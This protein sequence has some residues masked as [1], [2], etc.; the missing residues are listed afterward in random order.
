[1]QC[2]RR[3]SRWGDAPLLDKD[4]RAKLAAITD[5]DIA[6]IFK[7]LLRYRYLPV[8]FI[9][10]LGGGSLGYLVDRLNLL[11]RRPNVFVRRPVQQRANAF[12]NRYRLIYE[13]ADK[14]LRVMEE[15]GFEFQRSRA[16]GSFAHELM[17]CEI[18]ASF[19]LG[20]RDAGV[21]FITWQ[22]I[23]KSQALPESTRQ[24]PRPF[25]IPV[26]VMIDGAPRDIHI[27]ADGHPFGVG[28]PRD[29]KTSYFF[30]PGIEADCGTEPIDASNF[31]RSSIAKKFTAYLAIREGE[32]HRSHFGFPNLFVPIITTN[33]ARLASMMKVLERMTGGQGSRIFLFRTFP[34]FASCDRS[35]T[36]SGE[37]LTGDWQRVGY[38]PFNFVTL[39]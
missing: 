32:V 8:D 11:S 19:E 29:G 33:E 1:M 27:A 12:A 22:D 38:P 35:P 13:L 24:S 23:L 6:G 39:S 3:N 9:H 26:R 18:M 31:D 10:A 2:K 20:A 37:M 17:T 36:P 25:H 16:A 14:G 28:R 5:R 21:W 7:P 34:A 4:G 30:C 15:R